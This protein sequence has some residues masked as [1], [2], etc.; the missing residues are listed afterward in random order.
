M[1]MSAKGE[2][3]RDDLLQTATR[4]FA[5]NGYHNTS[6][7]DILDAVSVSKGAFYYHFK[8]KED[9]A[10]AILEQMRLNYQMKVIDHIDMIDAP[11]LR[12]ASMI[13]R[14][15]G[16]NESGMWSYCLLLARFV[17]ESSQQESPLARE[18]TDIVQWLLGYWTIIIKDA[19]NAGAIR[20]ELNSQIL[21]QLIVSMHLGAVGC[22]E[23]QGQVVN[24]EKVAQE[25]KLMIL[26]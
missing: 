14:L 12:P 24:M 6:T 23:L 1:E 8:S 10:L 11:G 18:V 7:Q 20:I 26:H 25:I 17:H 5:L 16:L 4:L 21:A 3:T 15:V 2:R 9:L 22:K 19:Q 13:D